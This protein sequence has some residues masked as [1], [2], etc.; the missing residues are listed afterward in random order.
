MGDDVLFY[1]DVFRAFVA[2]EKV[3]F[4]HAATDCE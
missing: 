4:Y 3:I 2:I 1:L